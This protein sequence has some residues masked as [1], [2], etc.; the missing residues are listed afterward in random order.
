MPMHGYRMPVPANTVL[1][2]PRTS[3]SRW[4]CSCSARCSLAQH[5]RPK[6][7]RETEGTRS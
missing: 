6:C 2:A 5:Q 4:W 1:F 7:R 3:R